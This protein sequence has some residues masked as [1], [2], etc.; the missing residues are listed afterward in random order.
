MDCGGC[1]CG[2]GVTVVMGGEVGGGRCRFGD[3]LWLGL[4]HK[5]VR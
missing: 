1:G 4:H 5:G 2:G 3:N